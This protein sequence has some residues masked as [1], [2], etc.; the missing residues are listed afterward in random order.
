[1]VWSQIETVLPSGRGLRPLRACPAGGCSDSNA[2]WSPDGKHLA[3]FTSEGLEA[4][5]Q[6][7]TGLQQI[8]INS[9]TVIAESEVTWAPDGRRLVFVGGQ[10]PDLIPH[11]FAVATDGTGLRQIMRGCTDEPT[12]SLTGTIAFS[13]ACQPP[14]TGIWTIGPNGSRLRRMFYNRYRPPVSPDWS[15]DGSQLAYTGAVSDAGQNIYICS[16]TG[17]HVR[18]LT[19]A[20][21]TQPAWSPNGKYI[22]FINN[23]GLYVIGRDGHGLRRVVSHSCERPHVRRVFVLG[24]PSRQ[25]LPR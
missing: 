14:Q 22:A 3:M 15:P 18:Q 23:N 9:P 19:T 5:G 11:L 6:N 21:G 12:W 1:L 13:A 20:F 8:K 7:G 4:I 24:S 10:P 2:V 16:A 17:K 25:P